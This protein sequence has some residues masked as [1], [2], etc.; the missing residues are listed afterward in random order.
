M[1]KTISPWPGS[2]PGNVVSRSVVHDQLIGS[3]DGAGDVI[4]SD[5]GQD[6]TD[7]EAESMEMEDSADEHSPWR[8]T[9]VSV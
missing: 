3:D 8:D 9:V 7:N 1:R 5:Q 2:E 6:D 4:D